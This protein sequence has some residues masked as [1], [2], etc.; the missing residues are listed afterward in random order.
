MSEN[1]SNRKSKHGIRDDPAA[2]YEKKFRRRNRELNWNSK[3][4]D[5]SEEKL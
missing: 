1:Q 3:E 5:N 4:C 2:L